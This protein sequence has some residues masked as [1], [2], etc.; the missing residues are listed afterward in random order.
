MPKLRTGQTGQT[1]PPVAQSRVAKARKGSKSGGVQSAT[2]AQVT[3]ADHKD[4]VEDGAHQSVT[5][6]KSSVLEGVLMSGLSH[7]ASQYYDNDKHGAADG[8]RILARSSGDKASLDKIFPPDLRAIKAAELART[9]PGLDKKSA[10]QLVEN[11]A[12]LLV[13]SN[14]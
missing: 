3:G 9:I 4:R 12:L 6:A 1:T 5:G 11:L 13:P 7:L 10:E 2:Q 14:A 8:I